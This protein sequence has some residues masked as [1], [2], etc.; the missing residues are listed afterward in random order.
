MSEQYTPSEAEIVESHAFFAPGRT[1][2]M[3]VRSAA[4]RRFISTI[5]AEALREAAQEWQAETESLRPDPR[6]FLVERAE[7]IER[8]KP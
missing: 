3:D 4:A 1:Q 7:T 6:R 8:G 5:K 2:N